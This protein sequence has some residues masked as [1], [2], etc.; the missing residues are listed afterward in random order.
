MRRIKFLSLSS[1]ENNS[2]CSF[3]QGSCYYHSRRTNKHE[4]MVKT[5]HIKCGRDIY[6]YSA[7]VCVCVCVCVYV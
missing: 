1:V 6:I 7:R 2:Y 3:F 4:D 5:Q